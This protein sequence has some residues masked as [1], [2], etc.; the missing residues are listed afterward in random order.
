MTMAQHTPGP[1]HQGQGNGEGS[2]FPAEGRMR[3]ETGGTTLYPI[4]SMTTGWKADEDSANARLIATA[5]EMLAALK[6]AHTAI[7]AINPHDDAVAAINRA[8]LAHGLVQAQR[9]IFAA[10]RK[11]EGA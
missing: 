8:G 2:I 6:A 1:W 9:A 7:D 4:C 5:P 3:M 10:I 11:A